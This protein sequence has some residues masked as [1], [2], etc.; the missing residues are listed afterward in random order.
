MDVNDHIGAAVF[1]L[2][3]AVC[4]APFFYWLPSSAKVTYCRKC[5]RIYDYQ[6][7]EPYCPV[8][9]GAA[10]NIPAYGATV[11]RLVS[12]EKLLKQLRI[13]EDIQRLKQLESELN[14]LNTEGFESEVQSIRAKLK[15][16]QGVEEVAGELDSLKRN[17]EAKEVEKGV[18]LA[19]PSRRAGRPPRP[20]LGG[21]I[22]AN[23][24]VL[25][26]IGFGGFA[27][28]YKAKRKTDDTIVALKIPR[29]AQF[30]T[31]EPRAFLEEADLWS[32]LRHPNIVAVFEYGIKP[33]PWITMEYMEG[34]SLRTRIG[35]LTVEESLDVALKV[36]DA[37]YYAHHLGVIHRDIKPENVL[38]DK[39]N[40][41][42]LAD[43]GLGKMMMEL[44]SKSGSPGTPSYSSPEQV[45][46]A[47]FGEVGW[48][49]D[50]YQCGAVLYEM[51]TGQLPFEGKSPLELAIKIVEGEVVRA[52]DLAPGLPA[53]LDEIIV[54]CL[55]K[56]KE[57]RYKDVSMM[58]AAL[59]NVKRSL[60]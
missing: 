52:S 15:K 28:I 56:D 32:R 7:K 11:R 40:N 33:Y 45:K 42:K 16:P 41:P 35:S 31:V 59:E 57:K 21:E 23:Y 43:W 27:D 38:F 9:H 46:P 55:G 29:L 12:K 36:C 39:E 14:A 50:I 2:L 60:Q 25:D 44:T 37:L 48:W 13:V 51:V 47:E 6:S 24:E 8:C 22:S 18:T 58:K 54:K 20:E 26:L 5:N 34:G 17:I 19:A 3:S 4:L 30:E 49:T 1:W 10:K 53:E